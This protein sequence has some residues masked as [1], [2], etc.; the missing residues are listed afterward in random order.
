MSDTPPALPPEEPT[1][2]PP[3]DGTLLDAI[4]VEGTEDDG[5]GQ[6][7]AK[8]TFWQKF[9]GE[10]FMA[11][12]AI[13]ILLVLIAAFLIISVSKESAKKDPNSFSTGSGGGAAGDKAK[14]FK[15]R[16]QPKNPKTTA[17]TPTRITSKSTTATIALPDVP[18]VAVSSMNAG[19]MGGGSSKGFGGGSGG[20]I[21]SGMGVGR[22]NG[23]N[24]VG[25]FGA[26]FKRSNAL[27]G[28]LYDLKFSPS[29][30]ALGADAPQRIAQ[31]QKAFE[32]MDRNWPGTK[33]L[34]DG[35]Y[36]QAELKLY[37]SNIFIPPRNAAEATKAFDCEKEI[38]APGWLAY[39]EGNFSPSVTGKYRF[40]GM[41][42]DIM[43]VAVGGKTVLSTFWPNSKLN[44]T[45]F[46]ASWLPKD[47]GKTDGQGL[48][49]P[50]HAGGR[51]S[52]E[53]LE[54]RKGQAYRIQIAFG[55]SYG[56]LF[57]AALL[58]EQQG[59]SYPTAGR[60][61][62]LPIFML[63]PLTP[64]EIQIKRSNHIDHQTEGPVFGTAI[65]EAG[66]RPVGR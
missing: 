49:F 47:A 16:L 32:T 22:G 50:P 52:G 37:A 48:R 8:R 24:F 53:W 13:H 29:G 25:A 3:L 15:T 61:T 64:E 56:G 7:R 9:G 12:V 10:G 66:G 18:T 45:R 2:P 41:A 17:K 28:T 54:L 19:L 36:R 62:Q 11:S 20:G 6:K 38:Q 4:P 55:E 30:K 26:S 23:K 31:I 58:I 57:S 40:V 21:G 65:N 39:Y 14:Q 5:L 63:E 35:R 33:A 44:V 42:D 59:V 46:E 27:E 1:A 51:F 60:D 34:L 43:V